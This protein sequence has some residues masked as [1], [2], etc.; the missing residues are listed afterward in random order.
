VRDAYNLAW[1]LEAVLRGKAADALLDT[2]GEERRPHVQTVVETAKSFGLI[3]GELDEQAARERDARLGAE[4]AAGTAPTIR[5]S[6]IP[7]LAAG[8][9]Y[10]DEAGALNPGAGKLFP[11]PWVC[12]GDIDRVRLDDLV[13]REFYVVS[14]DEALAANAAVH[15]A[16]F[17]PLADAKSISLV[18]EQEGAGRIDKVL[19]ALGEEHGL[20]KRW[21]AE[22]GAVA[23]VVRPDGFAYGAARS[24]GELRDMI[25]SL[26]KALATTRLSV[27]GVLAA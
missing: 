27:G 26:G 15:L 7:G 5:Q 22:H 20:V 1:K 21:L 2:Y 14:T 16:G 6:F 11:Q 9:L 10:R 19:I 4:L 18:D 8:L 3:I 13:C 23:A 17:G 12:G 25:A 24:E